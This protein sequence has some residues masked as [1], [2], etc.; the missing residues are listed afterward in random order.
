M[1]LIRPS[2]LAPKSFEQ[3]GALPIRLTATLSREFARGRLAAAAPDAAEFAEL[4]ETMGDLTALYGAVYRPDLVELDRLVSYKDM[5]STVLSELAPRL[6]GVDVVVLA[7]ATPDI[8]NREFVGCFIADT[9]PG[10]PLVFSISDQGPTVPFTALRLAADYLEDCAGRRALVLVLDQ[11]TAPWEMPDRALVPTCNAAVALVLEHPA[12]RRGAA[13]PRTFGWHHTGV[14]AEEIGAALASVRARV[15][16][17]AVLIAGRDTPLSDATI[18]AAEAVFVAD[19]GRVCTGVW[20]ALDA[21]RAD[22]PDGRAPVVVVDYD[23]VWRYLGI[24]VFDAPAAERTAAPES[25]A[26]AEG[27]SAAGDAG[28]AGW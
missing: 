20:H 3:H 13:G 28:Y 12:A 5:A 15:G 10:G 26:A 14:G 22:H 6:D 11:L 1:H 17:G 4:D 7:Y 18:A 23:P 8:D 19:R 27:V 9:V 24:A 2:G 16:R 21:Y 25:T